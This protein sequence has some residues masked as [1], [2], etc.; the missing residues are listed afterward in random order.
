MAMTYTSDKFTYTKASDTF[1]A[2]A[3]ELF[4]VTG[5]PFYIKSKQTGQTRLFLLERRE[6][7]EDADRDFVAWHYISPGNGHKAIIF[8]D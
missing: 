2:E 1:V 8:N 5:G 3:S 4:N 7:T 6:F